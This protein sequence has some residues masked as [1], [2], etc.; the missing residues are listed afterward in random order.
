MGNLHSETINFVDSIHKKYSNYLEIV[1][2]SGDFNIVH[3][4]HLR[5]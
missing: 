4:G 5:T 3:P 1:F 2:V